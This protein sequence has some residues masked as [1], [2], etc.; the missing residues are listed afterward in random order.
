MIARRACAVEQV[1]AAAVFVAMR[2]VLSGAAPACALIAAV[3]LGAG[4][5]KSCPDDVSK[6]PALPL[7]PAKPAPEILSNRQYYWITPSSPCARE[8]PSMAA[9][10][11]RS[12]YIEMARP[13]SSLPG[14]T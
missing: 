5:V 1:V 12:Q 3:A 8:M 7:T 2:I 11:I 10:A 14:T 13:A 4:C 9:R 6:C